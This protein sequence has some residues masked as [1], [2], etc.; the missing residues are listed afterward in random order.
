MRPIQN[1]PAARWAD[2]W[3][4]RWADRWADRWAHRWAAVTLEPLGQTIAGESG[5]PVAWEPPPRVGLWAAGGKFPL[6]GK[7]TSFPR[8]G[9]RY[10]QF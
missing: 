6:L 5:K 7:W 2:R 3:A 9:G 10:A 1:K 8:D 4:H